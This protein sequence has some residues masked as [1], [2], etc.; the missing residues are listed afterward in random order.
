MSKLDNHDKDNNKNKGKDENSNNKIPIDKNE[1]NQA[2]FSS[3]FHIMDGIIDQ[4]NKTKKLFIIMILTI[5]IIPPIAFM[6]TFMFFGL[7]FD[8]HNEHRMFFQK[9]WEDDS[10]PNP[11]PDPNSSFKFLPLLP[12]IV[13]LIW[14]G[15]GIRQW[16]VLSKWD[17]RYK[18]YKELQRKIDEKLDSD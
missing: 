8:D 3:I 16:F 14:L 15:I 18:R 7:P 6:L 5:M 17:K 11:G 10:G 13:A 4:L 12:V 2:D 9:L 1:D